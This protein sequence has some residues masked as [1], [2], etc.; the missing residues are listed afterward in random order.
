MA[1]GK[2]YS[3]EEVR[4]HNTLEDCWLIIHGKVYDVTPFMA[5]HPGGEDVM[6]VS[7]GKD[8]T[9]DFEDAHT[10]AARELLPQYCIGEIDAATITAELVQPSKKAWAT[11][12]KAGPTSLWITLLQL[13]AP[14]LLVAFALQNYTSTT[15]EY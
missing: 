11:K 3:F 7:T 5:E 12:P 9:V 4:K 10:E 15:T 6:L 13:A 2:V 1:G 8:A 14:L